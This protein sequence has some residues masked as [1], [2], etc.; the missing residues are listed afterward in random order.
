MRT[1]QRLRLA[2]HLPSSS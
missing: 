2:Y 1:Q